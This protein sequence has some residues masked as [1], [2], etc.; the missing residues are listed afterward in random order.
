MD[1]LNL[2]KKEGKGRSFTCILHH[3][4]K[5]Y[6][7]EQRTSFESINRWVLVLLSYLD[8]EFLTPQVGLFSNYMGNLLMSPTFHIFVVGIF[9]SK[10]T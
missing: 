3:G 7:L 2:Y 5:S 10:P 8:S 9:V 1:S 4:R 6:F